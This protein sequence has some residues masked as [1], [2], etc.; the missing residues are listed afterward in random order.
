MQRKHLKHAVNLNWAFII[1]AKMSQHRR[2]TSTRQDS[3]VHLCLKDKGHSFED[4]NVNLLDQEDRMVSV[5]EYCWNE[6]V[7]YE[8][9]Y[10]LVSMNK[11][12]FYEWI[13]SKW[14]DGL[15][16]QV[17]ATATGIASLGV[18]IPILTLPQVTSI[19]NLMVRLGNV[20][21]MPVNRFVDW[22]VLCLL[23]HGK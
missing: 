9:R 6:V 1:S 4:P 17:S 3:G 20:S 8:T 14:G 11:Y 18:S 13:F 2:A 10:H 21:H 23:S 7:D 5:N 22:H 15:E 12:C 19:T 16:N